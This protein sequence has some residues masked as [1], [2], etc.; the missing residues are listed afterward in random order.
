MEN[1][2]LKQL[3][4]MLDHMTHMA[5]GIDSVADELEAWCDELDDETKATCKHYKSVMKNKK[6]ISEA[7]KIIDTFYEAV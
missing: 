1:Q 3:W 7:L 6:M 4:S 2:H 5:Y